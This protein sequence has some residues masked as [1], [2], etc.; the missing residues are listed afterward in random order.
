MLDLPDSRCRAIKSSAGFRIFDFSFDGRNNCAESSDLESA[1]FLFEKS[2][3]DDAESFLFS[4]RFIELSTTSIFRDFD[5][6]CDFS[7]SRSR[8]FFSLDFF[9]SLLSIS[10]V[11]DVSFTSILSPETFFRSFGCREVNS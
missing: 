6:S 11:F 9:F 10:F 5:S 1:I 2:E 4:G 3:T 8:D 7:R